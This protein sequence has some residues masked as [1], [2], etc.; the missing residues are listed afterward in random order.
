VSRAI[1]EV[2]EYLG[3]TPAVAKAS[4]VN[5]RVVDLFHAGETIAPALPAIPDPTT[6]ITVRHEAELAVLDL[7]SGDPG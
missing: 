6:D 7:L 5:P 2:S 3:N 1:R 4:Y